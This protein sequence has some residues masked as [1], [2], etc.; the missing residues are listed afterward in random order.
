MAETASLAQ[1]LKAAERLTRKVLKQVEVQ[2]KEH[3]LQIDYYEHKISSAESAVADALGETRVDTVERER[4]EARRL[5]SIA[6][7]CLRVLKTTLAKI[8][9]NYISVWSYSANK[10]ALRALRLK[11]QIDMVEQMK[12]KQAPQKITCAR[13]IMRIQARRREQRFARIL[14]A[15]RSKAQVELKE[16]RRLTQLGSDNALAILR[17]RKME[18]A[19]RIVKWILW[20]WRAKKIGI[21]FS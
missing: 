5:R 18:Q 7:K 16:L 19:V 2:S 10:A 13:L 21:C 1:R 4:Q 12:K 11:V 20:H 6:Q 15:W 17:T 8:I 9:T 3:K 14:H